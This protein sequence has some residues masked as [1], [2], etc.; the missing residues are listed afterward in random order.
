[1]PEPLI[2][3]NHGRSPTT[4]LGL[5]AYL[6]FLVFLSSVGTLEW[7]IL[8][9][10]LF[11]VPAAIDLLRN[12]VTDFELN[13]QNIRWKNSGQEA[14]LPLSRIQRAR[15]DT[16]WDFSVR[17]TLILRDSS[18]LRIPQDVTPPHQ[19]LEQAFKD[20]DIA[21]ERHHFRVV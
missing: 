13:A 19:T 1:M 21:T 10:G 8:G 16:R 15:F 9:L 2:H 11:A 12:P 5:A 17:V 3:Q 20:R 6:G 14:E 18:K 7:I 4:M